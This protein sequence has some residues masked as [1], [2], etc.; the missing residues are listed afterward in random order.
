MLDV[1]GYG[2]ETD[3]GLVPDLVRKLQVGYT[4]RN[5]GRLVLEQTDPR[6]ETLER[7]SCSESDARH[8]TS[9]EVFGSVRNISIRSPRR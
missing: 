1:H 8:G 3:G 6:T 5:M 2:N 9:A 4:R 7:I